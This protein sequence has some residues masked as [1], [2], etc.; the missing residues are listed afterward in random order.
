MR[1]I[2]TEVLK[3]LANMMDP[4]RLKPNLEVMSLF[5]TLFEMLEDIIVERPRDFYT[6]IDKIDEKRYKEKV[7][8]L[9]DPTQCPKIRK[10]SKVLI[11]SLL[12]WKSLDT[13]TD[14]D[15]E[16]FSLCKIRRNSITH[17]MYVTLIKGLD[18]DFFENFARMYALFCK[19]EKWWITEYE[20][21]LNPDF[22]DVKADDV[23]WDGVMSGNMIA[24]SIMMDIISSGS[25]KNYEEVCKKLG[26]EVK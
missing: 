2:D 5:I 18:E 10:S 23:D 20:M 16:V 15:I 14:E 22:D 21:P 17:E 19:I 3:Q 24:M 6:L 1:E 12:W 25:N 13:I 26:I 7:L 8:D 9:Y 11:S 4:D